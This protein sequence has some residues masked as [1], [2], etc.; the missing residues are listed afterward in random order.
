MVLAGWHPGEVAVQQKLGFADAMNMDQGYLWVSD[1]MP[2][3]HRI[4]H[5]QKLAF[6]PVTTL[7][8]TGRPWGS[9]LSRKSGMP[10]FITSPDDTELV[11][12]V[13]VIE[14]DPIIQN[15]SGGRNLIAGLGIEFSTRRRNK[16]AGSIKI[17][18][19]SNSSMKL[20]LDVNQALGN[21][22][23][24]INVR[25]LEPHPGVKSRVV[26]NEPH[27]KSD[28]QLPQDLISFIQSSD[29][30]FIGTSYVSSPENSI[31]FPSHLGM[32]HRGGR[33]GFV[34]VSNGRT[35]VI[36]DYSGNR[37]MQSLGNVDT[38]ALASLT[39]LDFITGNILYI[40]GNAQ[41]LFGPE[42]QAIMPRTNV[43]TMVETTGYVFIA[44]ALPVIQ[45]PRST[46]ERSPYSPPVRFLAEEKA[47]SQSS[48][49]DVSVGLMRIKLH[50]PTVATFTF[51]SSSPIWIKPG[52]HV[53]I[54][55]TAFVGKGS[56][57]HM[58]HEGLE[59][60]LKD[61]CIRT[62]TVSSSHTSATQ[63]FELTMKE[64]PNG[65]ITGRLF[66]MARALSWRR[67]ELMEDTSP[68]GINLGLVGVG[69]DFTLPTKTTKLLF[70][71]GGI[72]ITP[73][74]SML[75]SMSASDRGGAWDVI[76]IISTREPQLAEELVRTALGANPPTNIH[77][78]LH[79]FTSRAVPSL[80]SAL[81]IHGGRLNSAFFQ[82]IADVRDRA[83]YVCGPISFEEM[84]M[85]GL[86]DAGVKHE[87]IAREN[88]AY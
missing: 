49:E 14:G 19:N 11:L 36:P 8:P 35:C 10:G 4:F 84:V 86:Q 83:V 25:T 87:T 7:D 63:T 69:G 60:S 53:I 21:C 16:F 23:K 37:M 82:T 80:P 29:T 2:P 48:F 64:K 5:N 44:N 61:D 47:F 67:P 56:Y 9:L 22:P 54:D 24:Y 26:Y 59:S 78:T 75:S 72:G 17:A 88:F 42:A 52:Q 30:V 81:T 55:L 71:A 43:I 27:L 45:K 70:V 73:F 15:I 58:A 74:L 39:F 68:L 34:R 28:Q 62:W 76:L 46:V 6:V 57:Q 38:T 3:E 32:N 40:T 50:T 13:D 77:F 33:P 79:L 51:T 66:N 1:Y 12:H 18:E 65:A 31:K 85:Q 41:N 20:T